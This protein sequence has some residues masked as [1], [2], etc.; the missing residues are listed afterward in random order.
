MM[1]ASRR[2]VASAATLE[3][4]ARET[5]LR[6]ASSLL[7]MVAAVA[8]IAGSVRAVQNWTSRTQV[9][10][11]QV[12]GDLRRVDK[13]DVAAR[14]APV[15]QGNY[16]TVDLVAIHDVVSS[17]AWWMKCV[18]VVGGRTGC[19]FMYGKSSPWHGGEMPVSSAREVSC[20]HRARSTGWRG[21]RCCSVR[22][23]SRCMSWS[24]T[25]P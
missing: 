10:A 11:V 4:P 17:S 18:S 7:V 25:V 20:L 21:C 12:D 8:F 5:V 9:A 15:V 19:A 2:T 6:Y 3:L 23:A 24:S 14:L 1:Q 22:P 13:R 16:F